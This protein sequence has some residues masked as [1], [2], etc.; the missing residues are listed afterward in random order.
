MYKQTIFFLTLL[1]L[2]IC[3]VQA[4]INQFDASGKRHGDWVKYHD[5]TENIQYQGRFYHGKE[6]DT[7]YYYP[8]LEKAKA[9]V[10]LIYKIPGVEAE[11]RFFTK[12]GKVL[13]EGVLKNKK[14][15]GV[16]KTY[17]TSTEHLQLLEHYENDLLDGERKVFYTNG[18]IAESGTYKNGQKH[19]TFY[20]YAMDGILLKEYNYKNGQLDGAM[21]IYDTDGV[22]W[23]TGTYINDKK[24]GL[25]K[26]YDTKGKVI[27]S[28][29]YPLPKRYREG[30]KPDS[31]RTKK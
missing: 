1:S 7:F 4:Q 12:S 18:Q 29:S 6:I 17:H 3:F 22:L 8:N 21:K 30:Y 28:I 20:T 13:S 5:S 19:G 26:T 14:R 24:D 2:S 25:W 10:M 16:W 11:A 31:L 27:D 15:F 9:S 23:Q